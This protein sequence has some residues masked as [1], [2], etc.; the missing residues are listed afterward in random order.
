MTTNAEFKRT[1]VDIQNKYRIH[2]KLMGGDDVYLSIMR[3]WPVRYEYNTTKF[4]QKKS[5]LLLC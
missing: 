5:V 1:P 3:H 4:N 2:E